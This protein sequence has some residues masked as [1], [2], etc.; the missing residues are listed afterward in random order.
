MRFA[1]GFGSKESK[2]L[3][4]VRKDFGFSV[5]DYLE[6]HFDGT[7]SPRAI[8]NL[9]PC[10]QFSAS[11]PKTRVCATRLLASVETSSR[12]VAAHPQQY[13]PGFPAEHPRHF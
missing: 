5:L 11:R 8:R 1:I 4:N 7:N 13:E 9:T 6:R 3:K 12:P 10:Q 2:H